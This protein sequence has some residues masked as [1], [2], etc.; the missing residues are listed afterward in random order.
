MKQKSYNHLYSGILRSVHKY[1]STEVNHICIFTIH[2]IFVLSLVNAPNPQTPHTYF[3]Y[4]SNSLY[5][6]KNLTLGKTALN[7]IVKNI[8]YIEQHDKC[9]EKLVSEE[10]CTQRVCLNNLHTS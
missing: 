6:S 3:H 5:K 7:Q 2:L 4:L 1:R 9:S 8:R 10:A